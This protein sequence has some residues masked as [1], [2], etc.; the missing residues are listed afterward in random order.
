M[1]ITFKQAQD[2]LN[3]E[4]DA[5]LLDVRDEMEYY[6]GHADGA[7]LFPVDEITAETAAQRL[8][9]K[10]APILI[11]CKTGARS[12]EAAEALEG[13]GYTRVYDIGSL[14]GWPGRIVHGE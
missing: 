1:R 4:K 14:V 6:M 9:D 10:N 3:T 2:I 7:A 8:P 12:A 11:Y 13:I 5:V